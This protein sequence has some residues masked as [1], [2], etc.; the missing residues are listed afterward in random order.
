[1]ERRE[2]TVQL[3]PAVVAVQGVVQLPTTRL[4]RAVVHT[5]KAV[6]MVVVAPARASMATVLEKAVLVLYAL[7]GPALQD[8]SHL[9]T[10][11]ICNETV[12]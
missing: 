7:F 10:Q 2:P 11:V 8:H 9:Q 3:L 1:M 5:V 12:Y 4:C 6:I